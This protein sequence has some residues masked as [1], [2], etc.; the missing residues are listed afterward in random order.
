MNPLMKKNSQSSL[1]SYREW[2]SISSGDSMTSNPGSLKPK[3]AVPPQ[4]SDRLRRL[5]NPANPRKGF[6]ACV[7]DLPS[8]R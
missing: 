4:H 5:S 2:K 7:V 3:D 1:M 6:Q 8:P